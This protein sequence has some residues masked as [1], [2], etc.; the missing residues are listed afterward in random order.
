MKYKYRRLQLF[1]LICTGTGA[2]LLLNFYFSLNHK[3]GS[4]DPF[5]YQPSINSWK[6]LNVIVPFGHFTISFG[7]ILVL[8]GV[9]L[10]VIENVLISRDEYKA[11]LN[12]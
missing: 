2:L 9:S 12:H 4:M 10:S 8:I 1:S 7:L 3:L 5:M 6:D 11:N